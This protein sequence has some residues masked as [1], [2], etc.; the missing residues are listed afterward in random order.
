M[1]IKQETID[2]LRVKVEYLIS[3]NN[4]KEALDLAAQY[5]LHWGHETGFVICKTRLLSK[6]NITQGNLKNLCC[7]KKP[8]PHFKQKGSP[9][10]LFLEN[11][12]LQKFNLKK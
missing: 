3:K 1:N 2:S 5:P 9:M 8:N 11:E 7:V 10:I 12:L 4:F 6:Y